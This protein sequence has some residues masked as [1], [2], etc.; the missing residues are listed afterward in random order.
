MPFYAGNQATGD[1]RE[2]AL[3]PLALVTPQLLRTWFFR[4]VTCDE[5]HDPGAVE[6]GVRYQPTVIKPYTV[7][8]SRVVQV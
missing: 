3:S 4:G 5:V 7:C 1:L 6:T 2:K 8:D